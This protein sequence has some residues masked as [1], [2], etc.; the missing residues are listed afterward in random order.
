MGKETQFI[1]V[2]EYREQTLHDLKMLGMIDSQ[3]I[4]RALN[5]R[6][7][8]ILLRREHIVHEISQVETAAYSGLN[9]Q[10]SW[11]SFVDSVGIFNTFVR[12]PDHSYIA[13]KV[14]G[15]IFMQ[16]QVIFLKNIS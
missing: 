13:R 3:Y 12:R 11:L 4:D 16:L 8:L 9:C 2:E 14:I 1:S 6:L 5:L 10:F 15:L 7:L